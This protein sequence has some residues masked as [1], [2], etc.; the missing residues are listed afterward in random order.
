[1]SSN[2]KKITAREFVECIGEDI[3]ITLNIVKADRKTLLVKDTS[4]KEYKISRPANSL[5]WDTVKTAD[6]IIV[7]GELYNATRLEEEVRCGKL[8]LIDVVDEEPIAIVATDELAMI[9]ETVL[10]RTLVG[11]WCQSNEELVFKIDEDK[12]LVV[13][14]RPD[15]EEDI[16]IKIETF[17]EFVN[18]TIKDM[19][20]EGK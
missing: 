9:N 7:R 15:E 11:L 13:T 16:Y 19:S 5:K 3:S 2:I 12:R 10:V 14:T 18:N 20:V 6:T 4:G 1:M 17:E 8:T